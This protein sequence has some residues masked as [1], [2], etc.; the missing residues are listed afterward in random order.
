M[1]FPF[2]IQLHW[3][4]KLFIKISQISI[5]II[6]C[7]QQNRYFL[8][9]LLPRGWDDIEV[10]D[11]AQNHRQKNN[12]SHQD[13]CF[14]YFVFLRIQ[15]SYLQGLCTKMWIISLISFPT[16]VK[17]MQVLKD[18]K[19]QYLHLLISLHACFV[20]SVNG[21]HACLKYYIDF[22]KKKLIK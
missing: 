4:T 15:T 7:Y 9:I 19:W 20:S 13:I 14:F 21:L 17:L 2:N 16:Y 5:E 8:S 12:N 3:L 1:F 6:F 18:R 22:V 10:Y 11:N